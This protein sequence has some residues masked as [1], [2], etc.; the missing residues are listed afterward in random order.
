M[1]L[2]Y[3]PTS[4]YARKVQVFLLEKRVTYVGVNVADPA[5]SGGE[6]N[7]SEHNPLGKVPTL[8]QDDGTALFD[9]RV[10]C[11]ALDLMYPAPRLIPDAPRERALVRHWE[12]LGDGI[13]D[14]LIPV[15][16]DSR[17][18]PEQQDR[19]H[20]AKLLGK[21]E[22]CLDY[23]EPLVEGRDTVGTGFSLADIALVCALGYI[24]LRR[25][26]LLDGREVL[27]A[28]SARQLARPSLA[29]TLPPN[30]PMRD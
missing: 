15:V 14:V 4:P 7:V 29:E 13:C 17:R 19:A 21:L 3:S 25:P 1:I 11:E 9:S 6:Q 18:P 5:R 26:E 12:A 2:F 22:A 20:V 27:G 23:I 24:K 30:V 8:V 16:Q 28:Y 10:I